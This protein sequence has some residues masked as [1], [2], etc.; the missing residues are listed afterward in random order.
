MH[1]KYWK[2]VK[3]YRKYIDDIYIFIFKLILPRALLNLIKFETHNFNCHTYYEWDVIILRINGTRIIDLIV[4]L[5]CRVL[6]EVNPNAI[7]IQPTLKTRNYILKW[8]L[9]S[10]FPFKIEKILL[11]KTLFDLISYFSYF[12]SLE[13]MEG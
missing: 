2:L 6:Q 9:K 8:R 1:L 5:H 4:L 7:I 10:V 12:F 11:K 13:N 3:N